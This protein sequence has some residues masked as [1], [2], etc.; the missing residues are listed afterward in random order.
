MTKNLAPKDFWLVVF[1]VPSTARSF[2]DGTTPPPPFTVPC[3]GREAQFL[4]IFTRNRTQGCR[5][6]IL[7]TTAAPRKLHYHPRNIHTKIEANLCS[8]L[9]KSQK[10]DITQWHVAEMPSL[11][12]GFRGDWCSFSIRLHNFQEDLM[13]SWNITLLMKKHNKSVTLNSNL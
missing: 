4:H 8:C 5:V 12:L 10:C 1:Y 9:K 3:E 11:Q 7:Y 6:A 13:S 2:R